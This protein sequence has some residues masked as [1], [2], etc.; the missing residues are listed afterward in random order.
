MWAIVIP[1][2]FLLIASGC[3]LFYWNLFSPGT[4]P[5]W[6]LLAF[7]ILALIGMTCFTVCDWPKTETEPAAFLDRRDAFAENAKELIPALD[8][9]PA[10]AKLTDYRHHRH[11]EDLLVT[12]EYG[13]QEY[14]KTL[15]W[16]TERYE[17][18]LTGDT[19]A[20]FSYRG[21]RFATAKNVPAGYVFVVIFDEES[22]QFSYLLY[23][24]QA[25]FNMDFSEY[26]ME[27]YDRLAN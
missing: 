1:I 24:E 27:L 15:R 25:I 22:F 16:E 12:V 10:E 26:K 18:D 14:R 21:K 7:C 13:E 3:I 2:A 8:H 19:D 20:I 4:N 5:R 9:L 17:L 11:S 6:F 23:D